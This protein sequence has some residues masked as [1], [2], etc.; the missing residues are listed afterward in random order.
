MTLSLKNTTP[1]RRRLYIRS[2][3]SIT[4]LIFLS[5]CVIPSF[6]FQQQKQY[7]SVA[8]W[9]NKNIHFDDRG[10][11][12]ESLICRSMDTSLIMGVGAL[13]ILG[14][15]GA[16]LLGGSSEKRTKKNRQLDEE[17]RLA[18][19]QFAKYYIEP[20]DRGEGLWSLDEIAPYDGTNDDNPILFAA[21]GYIF[22]VSKGRGFYSE[23]CEYHIFAG[24]DATRLL[25]KSK[26][27]EETPE[28][29]AIPLN[30]AE[31]ATLA[32]WIYTF[33]GKYDIVGRL[34]GHNPKDSELI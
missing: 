5:I 25:A 8:K 22:N 13:A 12:S 1:K 17:E 28:E 10:T 29:A 6:S 19:E 27:E 11:R 26:L 15:G 31:R 2:Q 24:R 9:G 33:K 3:S 18:Q 20:R 14:G 23:G 21:D 4:S 16:L 7:V 32:G 30:I 34:E